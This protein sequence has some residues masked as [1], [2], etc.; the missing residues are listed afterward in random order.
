MRYAECQILF[1]TMLNVF[2]QIGI[3]V[4]FDMLSVEFT[5]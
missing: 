5:F 1:I 3:M 4:S 2:M